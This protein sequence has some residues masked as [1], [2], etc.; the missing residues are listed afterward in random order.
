MIFLIIVKINKVFIFNFE[1]TFSLIFIIF[2][3][4][5]YFNIIIAIEFIKLR[6]SKIQK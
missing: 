4:I 5:R 3:N 2:I 6:N 1:F